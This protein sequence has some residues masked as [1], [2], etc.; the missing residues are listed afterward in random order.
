MNMEMGRNVLGIVAF[1]M[2]TIIFF[3]VMGWL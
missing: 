2:L 1:V 3:K